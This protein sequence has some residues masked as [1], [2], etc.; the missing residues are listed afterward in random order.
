[1]QRRSYFS[2]LLTGGLMGAIAGLLFATRPKAQ[3]KLMMRPGQMGDRA[4]R[5]FRGI[6]RGMLEMLR[7]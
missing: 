3:R 2:G 4:R 7:R 6:S 5:V 1:M